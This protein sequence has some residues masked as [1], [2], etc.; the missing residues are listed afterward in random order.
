MS[1][2][3]LVRG[4]SVAFAGRRV[5]DDVDLEIAAGEVVGLVGPSGSGKSLTARAIVG[6]PP[7]GAEV[8]GSV[9][10][11]GRELVG[12]N[13]RELCGVRGRGLGLVFQE[14]ATALDPVMPVGEQVA[15]GLRQSSR[16]SRPEARAQALDW[17]ARVGLDPAEIPPDRRPH[18]LSGGQRQ[19]AAIAAALALRPAVLIADEPTTALDAVTQAEIAAL[20]A[21]LAR[22]QGLSL[23]LVSHDLALLAALS[24]RLVVLE[25]GRRL[26][27]GAT[28]QVLDD[29]HPQ[30]RALRRASTSA[31][32]RQNDPLAKRDVVLRVQ[33]LWRTYAR[34]KAGWRSHPGPEGPDAP[35]VRDVSFDLNA[36]ERLAIVGETGAGK[37]T[38]LRLVLG[39]ERP[40][41][42][43]VHVAGQVFSPATTAARRA[44]RTRIQPVFQ[45]PASSFDPRWN[46]GRIVA[47]P[48]GLLDP[49]LGPMEVKARIEEALRQVGLSP[50]DAAQPARAFSG[51]QRQRIALARALAVRPQILVLDEA[52]SA[53]DAVSRGEIL[54]LLDG[55]VAATGLACLIVTHDLALVRGF[56]DTVAVLQAGRIV[57]IG[58][59]PSLLAQP[60]HAHTR[61]L[62]DAAPDLEQ[63]IARRRIWRPTPP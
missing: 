27:G 59:V 47:E 40:D 28:L 12:L 25:Q 51:G 24:D 55:L 57:E 42:G 15:E 22:A 3:L 20:L 16:A 11:D 26:A 49:P 34:A 9:R 17:L 4:L 13:E 62:L 6:L 50:D 39:L 5:V 1:P 8:S 54:A 38:L 29:P 46:V 44:L 2:R 10:L 53:L 18:Q 37:S 35:G 45:D 58:P 33:S 48:L 32:R 36:G 61:A 31:L 19:R 63:V 23:L 7:P 41:R 21:G 14:P 56:A 52:T 30:L 60:R 43:R